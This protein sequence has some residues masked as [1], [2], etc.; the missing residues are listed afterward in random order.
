M[1]GG[2]IGRRP[3]KAF[4]F[5]RLAYGCAQVVSTTPNADAPFQ[6]GGYKTSCAFSSLF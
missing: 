2:D 4:G 3:V 6:A 5:I 1:S